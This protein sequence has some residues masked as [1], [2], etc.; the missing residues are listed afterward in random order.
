MFAREAVEALPT[1]RTVN[2]YVALIP[3]PCI[4]WAGPPRRNVGGNKGEDVQGFM[5]H[6][7]RVDDFQQL[8]EGMF[9][10]TLVAAGN[11]LTSVNPAVVEETVV[12]TSG[13]TAESES[14]GA[15]VNIVPRDGGNTLRGLLPRLHH[16]GH[17]VRQPR[18][19]A[20]RPVRPGAIHFEHRYNIGRGDWRSDQAGQGVVVHELAPMG[21]VRLSPG[22]LL[23][24]DAGHRVLHA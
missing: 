8:R 9:F 3:G 17:S 19:R 14:G 7:S 24:H 12:Q 6:G 10:G 16:H 2:Q 18:R 22:A 23:E 5:I 11:R 1:N 13:S 4:R 15:L 21:H 20:S